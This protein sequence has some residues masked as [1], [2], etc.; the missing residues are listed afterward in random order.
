[1][2]QHLAHVSLRSFARRERFHTGV[3]ATDIETIL[4]RAVGANDLGLEVVAVW[5]SDG[6]VGDGGVVEKSGGDR[7]DK[8]QC[9]ED[10]G[11][12]HRDDSPEILVDEEKTTEEQY[13]REDCA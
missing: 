4:V 2:C 10:C 11:E 3:I 5:W 9:A 6:R 7:E 1:M 12:L 8:A 13:G